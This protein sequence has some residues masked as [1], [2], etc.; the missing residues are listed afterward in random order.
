MSSV[1]VRG[2]DLRATLT[3]PGAWSTVYTDG[4]QGEPPGAVES[5]MRSLKDRMLQEGLPEEDADAVLTALSD[6]RGLA[7]PS[8]R[9]LIARDGQ[10]AADEGFT[11][12]RLGSE[13]IAHGPFPE[14]V[15]LLRHRSGER[16]I[17]VVE[18]GRDGADVSLQHLGRSVVQVQHIEGEDDPIT[19]VS[20]GGWSQA[21]FQRS[22][23]EVWQRNQDE[24]AEEVD[25]IVREHR[26]EHIF[27]TGDAHA[28]GLLLES[29]AADALALVVEVDV[30]TRADGADDTAL[31]EEIE[32]TV[33]LADDDRIAAVRDR[34]AERDAESGA[35]GIPAVVGALQQAQ[36]DTLLLD[37]RLADGDGTLLALPDA[38]WVAIGAA[39]TF[40]AGPGTPVPVAEALARAAVLTDADVLFLE[41]ETRPDHDAEEPVA[42]LRWPAAPVTGAA[43]DLG[44]APDPEAPDPAGE[45]HRSQAEGE[46]PDEP[47]VRPDPAAEGHPSQA[48]G[49]DPGGAK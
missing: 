41:D 15:P 16:L 23:E 25:R 19:K 27:F 42:A 45:G 43:H 10:V 39:D 29:I 5:R 31:V 32:R 35:F 13:R 6:D 8:A 20:P 3:E 18:T 1:D 7:A 11:A 26:P 40:D 14:I 37:A 2:I 4:A 22:V 47:A 33:G 48:E 30:D 44:E 24:V 36:V 49:E 9:W 28:R 46:D 21:R 34:A 38:P 17:L 12:A